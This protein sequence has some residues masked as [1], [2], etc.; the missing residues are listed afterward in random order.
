MIT[1]KL[2]ENDTNKPSFD[3]F[4][5]NSHGLPYQSTG[6]KLNTFFS[7]FKPIQ[8][9]KRTLILHADEVL[10][11][12]FFIKNGYIRV[13]K[14]SEQGE[15]LTLAILKPNDLF[16]FTYGIHNL[17]NSYYL[18]ALTPIELWRIP[19]DTF[20]SFLQSQPDIFEELTNRILI[21]FGGLLTR[22]EYLVFGNA[23]TKVA[24][25]V[26]ICAKQFGEKKEGLIIIPLPLT[27]KDI[28]TLV[29]I[30]RETACLEMKK[31]EKEGIISHQGRNL[32]VNNIDL[33]ESISLLEGQEDILTR[34][35]L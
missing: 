21:R 32:V 33:L 13:Y 5:L 23:Y 1:N 4:N 24:S 8:Y 7:Q 9:K 12:I 18:E 28:A 14:I 16:P 26:L 27:H 30:T 17:P 10:S 20:V 15:E 35:S 19:Q 3:R 25:I 31:L 11:N 22:M 29:G 6:Q 34:Y 2:S